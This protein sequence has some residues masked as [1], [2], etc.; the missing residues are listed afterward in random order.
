MRGK[1]RLIFNKHMDVDYM[2]CKWPIQLA[3]HLRRPLDM[4]RERPHDI[5][6]LYYYYLKVHRVAAEA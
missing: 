6:N 2:R 1:S 3:T 5:F 4:A